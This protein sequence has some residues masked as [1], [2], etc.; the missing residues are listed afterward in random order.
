VRPILD[1]WAEPVARHLSHATDT[2]LTVDD[3]RQRT[4]E[5]TLADLSNDPKALT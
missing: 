5:R 1:E 3:P 2:P 4:V